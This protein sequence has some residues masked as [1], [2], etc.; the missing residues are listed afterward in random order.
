M[1]ASIKEFGR[2]GARKV[3]VH[4]TASR[5]PAVARAI[6]TANKARRLVGVLVHSD[7]RPEWLPYM[8]TRSGLRSIKPLLAYRDPAVAR[9]VREAWKRGVAEH[10]IADATTLGDRLLIVSC[11]FE[12]FEVP[13]GAVPALARLSDAALA[14]FEVEEDGAYLHWPEA[15][16]HL[17]LDAA[18][19]AL[20]PEARRRARLEALAEDA[21][22]GRA[23]RRVREAHGL[24]QHDIAGL[25]AR[26]VR[27]IE[28]GEEM[29]DKALERLAAAHR[30]AAE[31][32]LEAVSEAMAP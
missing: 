25:S 30:M 8:I 17:D 24:R 28:G 22:F 31:A 4:A 10:L 2:A 29:G 23:V 12:R 19:L 21:A 14:R 11:A 18:R 27:R 1:I 26:Q 3:I 32:Y 16:L 15:D 7:V 13:K 9:R 5:L 20:D 6:G